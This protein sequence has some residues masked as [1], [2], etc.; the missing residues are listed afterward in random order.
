MTNEVS[1][2][3]GSGVKPD[4][5]HRLPAMSALSIRDAGLLSCCVETIR[6]YEGDEV[7]GTVIECPRCARLMNVKSGQWQWK[8]VDTTEARVFRGESRKGLPKRGGRWTT[9]PPAPGAR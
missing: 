2:A 8:P 3:G 6:N 4:P 9:L 7:E 5:A 1:R